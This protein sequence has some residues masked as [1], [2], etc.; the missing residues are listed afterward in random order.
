MIYAQHF[1]QEEFR[2]WAEDMSPRLVT[3]LDV[4]RFRLGSAIAISA[5]DYAPGRKLGR[6]KMSERSIDEWGKIGATLSPSLSDPV[7]PL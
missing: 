2:D 5:S 1:S 3:M 6:G 7:H 4:L